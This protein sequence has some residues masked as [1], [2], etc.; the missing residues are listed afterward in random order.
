M[1]PGVRLP[2]H[3]SC[4]VLRPRPVAHRRHNAPHTAP[5]HNHP[6][7][8]APFPGASTGAGGEIQLTDAIQ[9]MIDAGGEVLAVPL[10][11]TERRYDVGGFEEYA[12]AFVEVALQDEEFGSSLREHIR[13][14]I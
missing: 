2:F 7:A 11:A 1:V 3:L 14:L 12:R 8:I 4:S 10:L 9:S 13:N 6:T 5:T